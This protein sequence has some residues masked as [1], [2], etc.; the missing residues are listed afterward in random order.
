[1]IRLFSKFGKSPILTPKLLFDLIGS[2]MPKKKNVS[3]SSDS[4]SGPDDVSTIFLNSI[5]FPR[6]WIHFGIELWTI[7]FDNLL[8]HIAYTGEKSQNRVNI[9]RSKDQRWH[10]FWV[11]RKETCDR[12]RIQRK[13]V[14]R[15]PWILRKRWRKIAWQKRH[16]IAAR[17][18]AQIDWHGRWH[19]FSFIRS[20]IKNNI[21]TCV[22]KAQFCYW[23]FSL[24]FGKKIEN[25]INK[26][27]LFFFRSFW[28]GV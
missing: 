8:I 7:D 6:E 4:D 23:F 21:K 15:Y 24:R 2:K 17:T 10:R 3:S 14:H 27:E 5:F 12:P 9:I 18:M 13:N 20:L 28:R 16:C 19:Q 25:R 11:G 22:S 26:I 1:M